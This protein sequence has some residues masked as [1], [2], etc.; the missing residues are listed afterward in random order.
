MPAL[1]LV[2]HCACNA[3]IS[4]STRC[5]SQ[6]KWDLSKPKQLSRWEKHLT[7][8]LHLPW[9]NCWWILPMPGLMILS[10]SYQNVHC[11]MTPDLSCGEPTW[12]N[13]TLFW[14]HILSWSVI[15]EQPPCEQHLFWQ[16]RTPRVWR[17]HV[18]KPIQTHLTPP[19]LW[20]PHDL[21]T[22]LGDWLFHSD[23]WVLWQVQ[24]RMFN[25]HDSEWVLA[26]RWHVIS[27]EKS[28]C[29]PAI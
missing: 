24:P 26:A 29:I 16:D 20:R 7:C 1:C 13:C 27:H 15:L 25:S 17:H 28:R 10:S 3:E 14:T 9:W 23:S 19:L 5:L 11:K 12:M 4:A 8:S 18:Q 21:A 2:L 22:T 6:L